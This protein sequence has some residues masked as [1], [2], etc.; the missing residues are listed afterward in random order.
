MVGS[1]T[2]VMKDLTATLFYVPV[3]ERYAP[4][5]Y[6]IAADV[7]WNDKTAKTYWYRENTVFHLEE[8]LHNRGK[9]T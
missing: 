4:V 6:S 2:D 5:A 9:I 7:H 3:L 1:F 8:S